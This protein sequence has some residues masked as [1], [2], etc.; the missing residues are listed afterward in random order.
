LGSVDNTSDASKPVSTAQQTALNL[1]A[2]LASPTFTGTVGGITAAMVG[3]P[4]GSGNSTG[5]NT[6]NETTTTVGAL[7]NAATSKTTPADADHIGLMDSEASNIWNKLSWANLKTTLLGGSPVTDFFKHGS[8]V[9]NTN[10][11][12]GRKLFINSINNALFRAESRWVVTGNLF[13]TADDSLVGA[14]SAASLA[15]LFDGSYDT[16]LTVP[17][18]NYAVINISFSTESGGNYPGYPYGYLYI[19]HYFDRYSSSTRTSTL[20]VYC[21]YAPHGIGWHTTSFGGFFSGTNQKI[22]S[23]RQSKYD[24][25]QFELK[26]YAPDSGASAQITQVDLNLDRPGSNEMPVVDKFKPNKLYAKLSTETLTPR[27]AGTYDLGESGTPYRRLFLRHTTEQLRVEYDAANYWRVTVSSAGIP[28]FNATGNAF[29]FNGDIRLD[30][31]VTA[32]G[33]TGA[34]TINKPIGSVNF[35]AGASSLVVTNSLVTT[36]SVITATVGTNDATMKSVAVVAAAGSFTLHA[37]AAATAE[38]RVNFH[39]F[40]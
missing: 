24:V 30:K 34:Q 36:S 18:G 37:N 4:S 17:V 6:G 9:M 5:T 20:S 19:S 2:N 11:F 39:V 10:A 26:I 22:D 40:N 12:G 3:A 35:A 27:V 25:S 21:N 23:A 28:T 29:V 32:G 15:T 33:T 7:L 16:Y 8:V 31:T 14:I 38:T 1:K 13:L